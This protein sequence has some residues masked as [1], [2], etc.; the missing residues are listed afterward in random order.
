MLS[1]TD[2]RV[3]NPVRYIEIQYILLG[4]DVCVETSVANPDSD[5]TFHF[6]VQIRLFTWM[7]IR[8]QLL[9]KVTGICDH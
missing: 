4:S 8:I 1:R 5:T 2:E 3:S 6:D 9:I 7:R